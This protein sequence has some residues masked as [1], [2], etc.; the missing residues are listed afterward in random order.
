M[1]CEVLDGLRRHWTN[2]PGDAPLPL[3]SLSERLGRQEVNVRSQAVVGLFVCLCFYFVLRGYWSIATAALPA[4]FVTFIYHRD[5]QMFN[6][7]ETQ[8]QYWEQGGAW[9]TADETGKTGSKWEAYKLPETEDKDGSLLVLRVH[10]QVNYIR[11]LEE[12]SE[13]PHSHSDTRGHAAPLPLVLGLTLNIKIQFGSS[14][15]ELSSL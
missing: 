13:V 15:L 4:T 8:G 5:K 3:L 12:G 11:C 2:S 14:W 1:S 9:Q 6:L 10:P 7:L